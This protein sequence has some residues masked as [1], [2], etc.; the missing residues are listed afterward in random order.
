MDLEG[1]EVSSGV[2]ELWCRGA[3]VM[4]GYYKDEAKTA[5]VMKDGWI[6]TGDLVRRDD[7]WN[8]FF[9]DRSKD[10]LKTGGM[11]VSSFEVQDAI[12]KNPK[13]LDVAV[14]GTPDPYWS[15]IVTAFVVLRKGETIS[16]KELITFCKDML[17]PYKVP[18]KV[19]FVNDLPRDSQ[20]KILKRVL[21]EQIK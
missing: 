12:Y 16:E 14:I 7:Q 17:A 18:K 4:G 3:C 6:H 21:R 5:Q 8:M 2:G 15:E 13:V 11:N 1:K 19:L 20:G 10:M 9:F